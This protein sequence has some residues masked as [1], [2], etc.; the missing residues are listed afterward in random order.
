MS[1]E[2]VA[3][4]LPGLDGHGWGGLRL[5]TVSSDIGTPEATSSRL[6]AGSW[7]A[8]AWLRLGGIWPGWTA[9]V[10]GSKLRH[11]MDLWPPTVYEYHFTRASKAHLTFLWRLGWMSERDV[12]RIC[13]HRLVLITVFCNGENF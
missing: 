11:A 2:K 13:G 6:L 7:P 3:M 4:P 8:G 12:R 9:Q 5:V 1:D 10:V